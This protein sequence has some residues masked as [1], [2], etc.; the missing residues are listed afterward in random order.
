MALDRRM[1]SKVRIEPRVTRVLHHLADGSS[2]FVMLVAIVVLGIGGIVLHMTF[3]ATEH[4][5]TR[6]AQ[7]ILAGSDRSVPSDFSNGH[8][9]YLNSCVSCHGQWAGG[10]ASGPPLV[11]PYYKPD[12]HGNV[13]FY[14]AI[15]QGVQAH[16]LSFGNMPAQSHLSKEQA[17]SIVRFVRWLQRDS[18]LIE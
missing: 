5:D 14:R 9:G 8:K 4:G 11:H 13:A 2:T 12:H 17:E 1:K 3:S 18:G 6:I 15:A 10:T 16:Q 7:P